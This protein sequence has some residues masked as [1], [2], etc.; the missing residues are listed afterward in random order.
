MTNSKMKVKI[1][2]FVALFGSESTSNSFYI[3]NWF[4]TGWQQINFVVLDSSLIQIDRSQFKIVLLVSKIHLWKNWGYKTAFYKI[5]LREILRFDPKDSFFGISEI[6]IFAIIH[7]TCSLQNWFFKDSFEFVYS[8][9]SYFQQP[10][11][12]VPILNFSRNF[13]QK[14]IV[15]IIY[16]TKMHFI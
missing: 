10:N 3:T 9:S 8:E 4:L 6:I 14:Y 15:E 16:F 7:E 5:H 1:E 12:I 13:C 2:S 11:W